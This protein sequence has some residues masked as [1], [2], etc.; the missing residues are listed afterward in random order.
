MQVRFEIVPDWSNK[1]LIPLINKYCE[2]G[3][4][5]ATDELS[6]YSKLSENGVKHEI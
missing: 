2:K 5:V 4:T 6:G 1:T 3:S